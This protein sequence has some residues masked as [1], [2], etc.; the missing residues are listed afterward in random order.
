LIIERAIEIIEIE[1]TAY[2]WFMCDLLN[3]KGIG[4]TLRQAK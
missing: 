1:R 2:F 4:Y 3:S